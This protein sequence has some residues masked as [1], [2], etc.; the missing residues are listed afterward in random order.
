[1][2]FTNGIWNLC[3]SPSLTTKHIREG[4]LFCEGNDDKT[5][6]HAMHTRRTGCCTWN[7]TERHYS[8][9]KKWGSSSSFG[10]RVSK[11]RMDVEKLNQMQEH[12]SVTMGIWPCWENKVTIIFVL[13]LVGEGGSREL[14]L[15]D[16]GSKI[17]AI[18]HVGF[19]TQIEGCQRQKWH[20]QNV[21]RDTETNNFKPPDSCIHTDRNRITSEHRT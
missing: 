6:L 2:D 21:H 4:M 20:H 11:F 3:I 14:A 5:P 15:I 7:S 8:V 10:T 16:T 9:R 19:W 17:T 18:I 1:M 13:F 12:F